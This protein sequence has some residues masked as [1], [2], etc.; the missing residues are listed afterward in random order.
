MAFTLG[1]AAK[2]VGKSKA[3]ISNAIKSGKITAR[4]R[5]SDGAYQI[6]ASELFRVYEPVQG[7]QQ[8][9]KLATGE[10]PFEHRELRAD[11]EAARERAM[12]DLRDQIEALRRD[13]DGVIADLRSDR[14]D[15]RRQ[16]Q[17]AQTTIRA[18][19][20]QRDQTPAPEPRRS[21]WARVFGR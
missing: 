5:E 20:D 6:E 18:L 2:A 8:E 7:E 11:L 16:A 9:P 4:K 13:K 21:L 3:T 15:W 10:T 19:A 12:D 17:E 14:D 1:E